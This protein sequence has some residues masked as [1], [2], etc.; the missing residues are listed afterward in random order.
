M[1]NKKRLTV[2]FAY[3]VI[4]PSCS[5]E[6]REYCIKYNEW[7][8]PETIESVIKALENSGNKVIPIGVSPYNLCHNNEK[9]IIS[10]LEKHRDE[11]D[12]VFNITEG[13]ATKNRE[14]LMPAI[15]EYMHIPFTGSDLLALAIA[16]NKADTIEILKNYGIDTAPSIVFDERDKFDM[17]RYAKKLEKVFPLVVKP[18]GEGTSVGMGQYSVVENLEQLKKAVTTVITEYE[19]P[20]FVEKYLEGKEYTVGIIGDI[21]LPILSLDLTKIPGNPKV[22]DPEVKEVDIDYSRVARFSEK[23]VFLA[24]QAATAHTALSCNDYNRMDFRED[25]DGKIYF[26]ESNP[27]P[28]L[29]PTSSD[30]PKMAGLAGIGYDV[31]VNLILYEAI[32]RYQ[33]DN[34]FGERFDEKRL[35]YIRDFINPTMSSLDIYPLNIPT[36]EEVRSDVSYKL[37]KVKK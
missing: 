16:M 29:N 13:L 4:P 27:L 17:I 12:M 32:K 14:S 21:I 22:R 26:L 35:E 30:L 18:V 10:K 1:A 19:Q 3:D 2:G 25:D 24:A 20:A 28:G 31:M 33:S 6:E 11:L 8:S 36:P 5:P 37:M 23:Y 7:D 9:N 15:M 34:E